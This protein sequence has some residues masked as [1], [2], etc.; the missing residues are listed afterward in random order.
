[1][2][3]YRVLNLREF[4]DVGESYIPETWYYVLSFRILDER[5][6]QSKR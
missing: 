3:R 2:T 6:F 5:G 4:S 1:M